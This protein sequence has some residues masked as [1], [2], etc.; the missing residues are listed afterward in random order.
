MV[1]KNNFFLI[2]AYYFFKATLT[3]FF[4]GKSHKEVTKTV[5]IKGSK[6]SGARARSESM[7]S[8]ISSGSGSAN[9]TYVNIKKASFIYILATKSKFF[10][11]VF[12]VEKTGSLD[13]YKK[14]SHDTVP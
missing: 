8:T 14:N 13:P 11:P 2:L 10:H 9:T 3:T 12:R 7:P 6:V 1:T 4:K 5:E